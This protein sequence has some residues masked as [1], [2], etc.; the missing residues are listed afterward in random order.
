MGSSQK[1]PKGRIC[2]AE[3]PRSC[4]SLEV[5]AVKLTQLILKSCD[6]ALRLGRG[7]DHH[8]TTL[9]MEDIDDPEKLLLGIIICHVNVLQKS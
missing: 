7:V 2:C 6:R 9:L 4:L 1:Q 5:Q 8:P 3:F